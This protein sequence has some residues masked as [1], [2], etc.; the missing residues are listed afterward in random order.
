MTGASL[1]GGGALGGGEA[2]GSA[3][4]WGQL[5]TGAA[6]AYSAWNT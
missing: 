1:W 3:G 4:N 6:N 5:L 2:K